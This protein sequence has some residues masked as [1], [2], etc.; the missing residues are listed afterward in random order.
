MIRTDSIHCLLDCWAEILDMK[1]ID[2]RPL[3][4]GIW[5]AQ[6][7]VT[8]AGISYYTSM[9]DPMD[10]PERCSRLFGLSFT[11]WCGPELANME[12]LTEYLR[13]Q[14]GGEVAGIMYMDLYLMPYSVHYQVKHVPHSILVSYTGQP[15]PEAWHIK[16]PYFQWEGMLPVDV[17]A[18]G[19]L[20]GF[21]VDFADSHPADNAAVSSLFKQDTGSS[22]GQ[23]AIETERLVSEAVRQHGGYAPELLLVSVQEAG[24]VAKRFIGYQYILDYLAERTGCDT[25]AGTD[26]VHLLRKGWESLML[27]IARFC[28]VRQPVDLE[29]FRRKLD[30]LEGYE[31]AAKQEISRALFLLADQHAVHDHQ[32]MLGG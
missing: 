24:T 9:Q 1:N 26:A 28:I 29:G 18:R 25:A 10:W 32:A 8:E 11:H 19:F 2:Y 13:H 23:L 17:L 21:A 14:E 4:S 16:D 5:N 30:K 15:E 31:Q 7:G 27:V 22:P 20:M 6:F 3:Y 12:C